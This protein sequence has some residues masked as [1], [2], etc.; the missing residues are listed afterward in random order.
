LG[1]KNFSGTCGTISE[2]TTT[3]K[4]QETTSFSFLDKA[5]GQRVTA[6]VL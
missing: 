5:I 1:T 3:A 2:T 6:I 4:Q